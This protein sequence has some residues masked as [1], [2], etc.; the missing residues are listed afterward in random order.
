M[1]PWETSSVLDMSYAFAGATSFNKVL[2][3]N[4]TQVTTMKG[5]FSG[6]Y[7]FNGDINV[8]DVSNVVDLSEMVSA[9]TGICRTI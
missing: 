7:S 1:L 8:F 3:W 5:M 9:K 6:A 2:L 4:T